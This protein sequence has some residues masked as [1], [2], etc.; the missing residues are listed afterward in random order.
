M[1][2]KFADVDPA[3]PAEVA[4]LSELFNGCLEAQPPHLR[5]WFKCVAI[6]TSY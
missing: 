5:D 4:R 3:S 6:L 1:N 2:E